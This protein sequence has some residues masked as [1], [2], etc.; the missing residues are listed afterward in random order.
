MKILCVIPARYASSRF[1]GKPL[2]DICGKTMIRRV[3][4]RVELSAVG[5]VCVATDDQRIFDEVRSFG[6]NVVMTGEHR[7][8][9]DRCFEAYKKC[10]GNY[11][12]VINIQ[13]DEPLI[14][15]EQIRQLAHSLEQGTQIVTMAAAIT[16]RI[17]VLDENVVK[18]VFNVAGKALYFSRHA[19]PFLRGTNREQWFDTNTYF[20]HIGMYGFRADVFAAIVKCQPSKLE[21]AESLEQ[22]RWLEN[23]YSIQVEITDKQNY[24]VDTQDD[25]IKIVNTL[26]TNA[27]N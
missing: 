12:A 16:D 3:Y 24:S 26:K 19:I 17:E 5:D 27:E 14:N 6:G 8:G 23:G 20:K 15:P 21:I 4:E 7:S 13:G 22:L 1:P 10:G 18:V 9:T 2:A 25:L 11:D